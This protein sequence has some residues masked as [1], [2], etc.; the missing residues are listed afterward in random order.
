MA[1]SAGVGR[2]A[3]NRTDLSDDSTPDEGGWDEGVTWSMTWRLG[4]R[5]A[6]LGPA[7]MDDGSANPLPAGPVDPVEATFEGPAEGDDAVGCA[8]SA[9]GDAKWGGPA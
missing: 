4:G 8:F 9:I 2:A 5:W 3:A 1:A 6:R 7:L